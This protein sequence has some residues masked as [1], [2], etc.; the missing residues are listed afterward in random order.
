[1]TWVKKEKKNQNWK[2][3]ELSLFTNNMVIFPENTKISTEKLFQ[4]RYT[5][6]NVEKQPSHTHTHQQNNTTKET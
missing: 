2:Q 1:M 4:K 6:E 5:V 3:K